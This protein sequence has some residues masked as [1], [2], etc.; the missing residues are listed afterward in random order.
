MGLFN[1]SQLFEKKHGR[2]AS[3]EDLPGRTVLTLD[4]GTVLNVPHPVIE[5][6]GMR[7]GSPPEVGTGV[8]FTAVGGNVLDLEPW[9]QPPN[10]DAPSEAGDG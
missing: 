5:R 7:H 9:I 8:A 1:K 4:D 3:T 6:W 10:E 2:V